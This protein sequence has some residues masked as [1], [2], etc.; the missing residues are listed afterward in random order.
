M[1]DLAPNI[2]RQRMIMEGNYNIKISNK[3][4]SDYLDGLAKELKM[5]KLTNPFIFSPNKLKH[6]L[7]HGIAGFIGWA[8]S[9]SSVYTWDKFNFFTVD[10]YTC[11]KFKKEKAISFS[12]KFFKTN[13]LVYKEVT[14]GK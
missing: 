9:G 12:K 11:K 10:I 8:E 2:Y 7:H 4:I 6:P 13:K 1:K 14:Y 3:S 5:T